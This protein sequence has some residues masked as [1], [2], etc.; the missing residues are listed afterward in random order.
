MH[1]PLATPASA[2]LLSSPSFTRELAIASTATAEPE[3]ALERTLACA[4]PVDSPPLSAAAIER[5]APRGP[6]ASA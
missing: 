4:T 1:Q 3:A 6:P 5:A 2:V